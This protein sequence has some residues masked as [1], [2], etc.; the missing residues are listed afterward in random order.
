MAIYLTHV[1]VIGV[2]KE[3]T[4]FGDH[5]HRYRST[6]TIDIEG[7]IDGRHSNPD[8][9]GTA[10]VMTSIETIRDHVWGTSTSTIPM[11][12]IYINGTGLGKGQIMSINFPASQEVLNSQIY[13]GAYD[14][15]LQFYESGD[16]GATLENVT[17][18][19]MEFL[20]EFSES[21][22]VSLSET[23]DYSLEHEINIKYLSGVRANGTS[24]D[25]IANAKT[26]A[27][28]LYAHTPTQFSTSLGNY[29]GNIS[30]Q[31]RKRTNETYDAIK[32][33]ATFSRR[34]S[35]GP[36][37]GGGGDYSKTINH[38]FSIDQMGFCTVKE[39]GELTAQDAQMSVVINN[40]IINE[41]ATSYSRCNTIY[42]AYKSD[43]STVTTNTR[44]LFS[45]ATKVERA[46]NVSQ[47]VGSYSI[48][49]TDNS[50]QGGGFA[51]PT[52][53]RSITIGTPTWDGQI[54]VSEKGT[55]TQRTPVGYWDNLWTI[56][57]SRNEVKG[58]CQNIY[59][60]F[61]VNGG[62]PYM[63]LKNLKNSF[64]I[65]SRGKAV[66][67]TYEFTDNPENIDYVAG[68]G[69]PG[70][71]SKIS[72]TQTTEI[73]AS[74]QTAVQ[75]P[76]IPYQ[77]MQTPGFTK[78]GKRSVKFDGQ[79][80]RYRA[81]NTLT[82]MYN[83]NSSASLARNICLTEAYR[84]FADNLFIFSRDMG[85]LYVDTASYTYDSSHK[86]TM[87]ISAV[88]TMVRSNDADNLI[89]RG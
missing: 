47:G 21:F 58:R 28:N 71:F 59:N 81:S 54:T 85:Q 88:Y 29:Y 39:D 51:S 4:T 66:S 67:Y 61:V 75:I 18:P 1:S 26:L 60:K 69:W 40:A 64:S 32:G 24:V 57:P 23:Q 35:L 70:S 74:A 43:L 33:D 5:Q 78:L 84:V 65:P 15:T 55:V 20:E 11:D 7:F 25:P 19:D 73:G 12:D 14:A 10:G 72:S 42:N 62:S 34:M 82:T 3:G 77:V 79:L 45:Q 46:N 76:N 27:T 13:Y 56:L 48:T 17:I 6:K 38:N 89:F 87:N 36:A 8:N 53:D 31:S 41:I 37:S 68:P 16:I 49:Y 80:R 2:S 30:T 50:N 86:F 52:I 44:S 63:S 9:A 22:N 83:V